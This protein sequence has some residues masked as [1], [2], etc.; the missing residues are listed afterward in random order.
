MVRALIDS[1]DPPAQRHSMNITQGTPGPKP[2]TVWLVEDNEPYRVSL[3][4]AVRRLAGG[5]VVR[6]FTECETALKELETSAPPQV[7]LLDIGLPGISGLEAIRRFKDLS[8]GLRIIMLTSFDDHDR[9]VRAICAG[10]SGYMLKTSPVLKVK[11]AIEE[12]LEGGAPMSPQIASAM[13]GLVAK[14]AVPRAAD[15]L[16]SPRETEI[17]QLMSQGLA[18]KEIGVRLGASYHTVDTHI[19]RV[20]DKLQVHSRAEAV[21]KGM[22]QGLL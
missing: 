11:E 2:I 13:L 17:L 14:L 4:K 5:T 7:M 6:A 8:P 3:A 20:Y 1:Y 10:A 12:V 19:R 16:L 21:A 15:P 18:M 22:K 9:V